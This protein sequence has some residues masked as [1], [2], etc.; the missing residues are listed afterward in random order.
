MIKLKDLLKIANSILIIRDEEDIVMEINDSCSDENL[1]SEKL[2]NKTVCIV[3][4]KNNRLL[5]D[6]EGGLNDWFFI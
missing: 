4:A 3:E 5:V 1:L 6:L 2:L